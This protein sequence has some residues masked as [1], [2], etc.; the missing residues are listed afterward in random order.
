MGLG[1]SSLIADL[2]AHDLRR[3]DRGEPD[4]IAFC[5]LNGVGHE[6]VSEQGEVTSELGGNDGSQLFDPVPGFK[7]SLVVTGEFEVTTGELH[8]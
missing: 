4:G 7:W 8:D 6:L 1:R 5:V 2:D 3:Y